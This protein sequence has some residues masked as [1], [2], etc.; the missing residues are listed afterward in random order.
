MQIDRAFE[1]AHVRIVQV[2]G[3]PLGLDEVLRPRERHQNIA[4]G[5]AG[6][7]VAP[8]NLRGVAENRNS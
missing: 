7:P 8:F 5:C 4:I 1:H 6:A 3:E 2:L